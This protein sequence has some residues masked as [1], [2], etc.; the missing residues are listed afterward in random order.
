MDNLTI[1]NTIKQLHQL[2]LEMLEMKHL[3]RSILTDSAY[4]NEQV[5]GIATDIFNGVYE[6]VGNEFRAFLLKEF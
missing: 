6:S 5:F 1:G 4:N 3:L 2:E